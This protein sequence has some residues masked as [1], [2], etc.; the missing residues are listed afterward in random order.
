MKLSCDVIQDLL[1]L[2]HDGV[3]S[4]A[5]KALVEEH[6]ASCELCKSELQATSAAITMNQTEHNLKEAETLQRLSKRWKKGMFTSL[7]KGVLFT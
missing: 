3:C 2:Y 6:L 4:Q 5:S 7:L 1:P